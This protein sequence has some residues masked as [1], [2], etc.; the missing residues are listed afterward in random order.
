MKFMHNSIVYT[1]YGLEMYEIYR[2]NYHGL[3]MNKIYIRK[4]QYI[5]YNE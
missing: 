4:L 2:V 3:V 1:F 5:E